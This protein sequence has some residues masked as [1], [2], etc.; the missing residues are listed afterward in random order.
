M[1]KYNNTPILINRIII[2]HYALLIHVDKVYTNEQNIQSCNT[3]LQ[4]LT[5]EQIA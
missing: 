5:S 1:K 4:I 2:K 3:L